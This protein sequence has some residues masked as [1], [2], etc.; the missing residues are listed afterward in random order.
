MRE[1]LCEIRNCENKSPNSGFKLYLG[2]EKIT[3]CPVSFINPWSNQI[4][5]EYFLLKNLS[6]IGLTQNIES[7]SAKECEAFLVVKD[8]FDKIQHEKEEAELRKVNR[9]R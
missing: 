9:G 4:L 3:E 2:G 8:T 1:N 5:S 7:Y 6:S